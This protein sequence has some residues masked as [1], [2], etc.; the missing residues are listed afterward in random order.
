MTPALVILVV[1]LSPSMVGRHTP[2][3]ARLAAAG[4]M[5]PLTT[6]TPAVTCT[7]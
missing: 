1:G 7:V 3:L 5:R 6:V 4:A 2:N